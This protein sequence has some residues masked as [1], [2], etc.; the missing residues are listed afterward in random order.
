LKVH[1]HGALNIGYSRQE[2][3]VIM[4]MAVYVGF[5]AALN[6]LFAAKVVFKERDE[7]GKS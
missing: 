3:E 4:Q 1:I 2:V 7:L 6:G 5:P